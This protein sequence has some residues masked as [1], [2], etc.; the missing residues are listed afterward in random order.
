MFF[1]KENLPK[2]VFLIIIFLYFFLRL[3]NLPNNVN[4][5]DDQGKILLTVSDLW[6]TKK[7]TLLGPPVSFSFE[8]RYFY[9][10]PITYYIF[11]LVPIL[12]NGN[13]LFG[14]MVVVGINFLGL[15][16]LFL[17]I[18]NK[19]GVYFGLL[20]A[21]LFAVFPELVYYTKFIWNPNF[22]PFVASLLIF[23][24]HGMQKTNLKIKLF[25]IGLFLALG[26]QFH[27]QFLLIIIPVCVYLLI[28]TKQKIMFLI[29]MTL[30]FL[31]G[32]LPVIW[33]ELRNDFYNL[34][35]ILF[36]V[37]NHAFSSGGNLPSYYFLSLYPFVIF[38]FIAILNW[39]NAKSQVLV[40]LIAGIIV[41]CAS[42]VS[43]GM[44]FQNKGMPQQWRY[45]D[46][47]KAAEIIA[48]QELIQ[49][50][51]A[52]LLSGD[53]RAYALRYM[54]KI[55]NSNFLNETNYQNA[56]YLFVLSY[57][58]KEETVRDPVYE[59]NIFKGKVVREWT[60]GENSDIY[61]Y[62]LAK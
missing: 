60:L 28:I 8:G 18:K 62:L 47:Q 11:L 15:A 31:I 53:T 46:L 29:F 58:N 24:L 19:F 33:F 51:V 52:N 17:A 42:L 26:L 41:C 56:K 37:K 12:A 54:L 14:S 40:K 48:D 7:L 6:H 4:F 16:F 39:I 22:L 49:Y 38:Y 50:N 20:G 57:K 32:Y 35:T 61:L 21:T 5:S 1:R 25:L 30:G 10:G 3:F 44:L 2:I 59:I 9:H 34:R 13:P 36:L 45:V 55:V 27:Y 23:L 43:F